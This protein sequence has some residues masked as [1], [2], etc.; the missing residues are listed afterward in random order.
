MPGHC[1]QHIDV[2]ELP[3]GRI[4]AIVKMHVATLNFKGVKYHS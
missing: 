4:L 1:C 3:W 2:L